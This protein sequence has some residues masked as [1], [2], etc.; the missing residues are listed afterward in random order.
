MAALFKIWFILIDH[1]NIVQMSSNYILTYSIMY[2][3]TAYLKYLYYISLSLNT[4][5]ICS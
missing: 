4:F 5:G 2:H 3:S 1:Y